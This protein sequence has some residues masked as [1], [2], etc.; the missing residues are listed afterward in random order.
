MKKRKISY[1][2][3]PM[4]FVACGQRA[5]EREKAPTLIQVEQVSAQTIADNG[6]TYVG[7][8]EENSATIV[9]FT[10][11]GTLQRVAVSEGQAVVRG[12]LIAEMDDAQARNMLAAAEAQSRQ[13]EDALVRYKLLHDE[14]SMTEAGTLAAGH[15]QK[16][17]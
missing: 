17:P 14:G 10:G 12:Q 16:E 13:A 3:I 5:E 4:L 1:F 15:C 6:T 11:M 2:M 7:T 9:S 8:I